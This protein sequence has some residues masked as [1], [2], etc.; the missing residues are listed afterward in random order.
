M[1]MEGQKNVSHIKDEELTGKLLHPFYKVKEAKVV[2]K[3]GKRV[4]K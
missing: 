1:F 2:G 3:V 4:F